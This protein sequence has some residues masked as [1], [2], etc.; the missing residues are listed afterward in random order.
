MYAVVEDRGQQYRVS[1]G[2]RVIIDRSPQAVGAELE[3]PVL[4][5]VDEG[6]PEIGKPYV[7]EKTARCKVVAHQRGRKG[8]AGTFKRRK[9]SRRRIG[10]RAEQTVIEVVA[11]G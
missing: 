11:I 5:L 7:A 3:L 6:D 8:V 4:L 9:D 10:Y 1:T 2:D